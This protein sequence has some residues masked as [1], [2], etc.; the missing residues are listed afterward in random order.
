MWEKFLIEICTQ[1]RLTDIQKQ[2]LMCLTES[3]RN[4]SELLSSYNK[5][6]FQE[7]G[8]LLDETLTKRLTTIYNKFEITNGRNKFRRLLELL[9]TQYEEWNNNENNCL[10]RTD[11][12]NIYPQ[13]PIERFR[14]ELERV[15]FLRDEEKEIDILQTFAP[16]LSYYQQQLIECINN[17]VNIRI[18]LAWPYSVA[19]K[20][21]E[22]VLREYL[23]NN[24]TQLD[25]KYEV[26]SN[27]ETLAGILDQ[28]GE[29]KFLKIKL[30]DTLPSLAIYRVG[31]YMI[32]GAFLHG[33]LAVDTFQF[34]LDVAAV[35][36][37]ITKPLQDN[38]KL[39]WRV[40]REFFPSSSRNWRNDLEDLF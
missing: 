4:K 26:M 6:Y 21:R 12:R 40:A 25:I 2:T 36:P 37:I 11:L 17:N 20:L 7:N 15:P 16:N 13:F 32:A 3:T 9:R 14:D 24:N 22:D 35:N 29:T 31:N 33:A 23:P 28:V 27:L 39:L 5:I 38:F 8:E 19:A 18:L 1:R 10:L 34:E 30:Y